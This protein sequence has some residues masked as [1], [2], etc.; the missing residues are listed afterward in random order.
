MKSEMDS[1]IRLA[2]AQ[3]LSV[4]AVIADVP[5][6]MASNARLL[7]AVSRALQFSEYS[8]RN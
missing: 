3:P 4:P 1:P 8:R 5:A 6:G 7:A 2:Q